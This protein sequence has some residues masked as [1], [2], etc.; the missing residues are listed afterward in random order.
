M[1]IQAK[2]EVIKICNKRTTEF[3]FKKMKVWYNEEIKCSIHYCLRNCDEKI[4]QEKIES[5]DLEVVEI[6]YIEGK[7]MEWGECHI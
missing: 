6:L 5:L 1:K 3:I 7:I 4:K 2:F